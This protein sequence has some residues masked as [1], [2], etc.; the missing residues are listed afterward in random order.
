[1]KRCLVY[2]LILTILL[3]TSAL[4]WALRPP[5]ILICRDGTILQM[6]YNRD[7]HR[8]TIRKHFAR[9][10]GKDTDGPVRAE[11]QV[12]CKKDDWWEFQRPGIQYKAWSTIEGDA[13]ED[14]QVYGGYYSVYANAMMDTDN[15]KSG[16]RWQGT[17]RDKADADYKIGH[18]D[19]FRYLTGCLIQEQL[20]G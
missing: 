14:Y 20:A 18:Q 13:P 10:R 7:M 9:A 12:D 1:M 16:I 11:A 2:T 17:A 5:K 3:T 8:I 4:L 15:D 6:R 19:N